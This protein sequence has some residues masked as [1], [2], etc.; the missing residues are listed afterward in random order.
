MLIADAFN[1]GP[2]LLFHGEGLDGSRFVSWCPY[3]IFLFN[4]A[5]D[6]QRARFG[7]QVPRRYVI[8]NKKDRRSTG[9]HWVTAVYEKKSME[10]EATT[11]QSS[12]VAVDAADRESPLI[13]LGPFA[14]IRGGSSAMQAFAGV[15]MC[16][17][18]GINTAPT[19]CFAWCYR[20][21]KNGSFASRLVQGPVPRELKFECALRFKCAL[22]EVCI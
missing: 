8:L 22:P 3:E 12:E 7:H 20:E 6:I 16:C 17:Y 5:H 10:P 13:P 18:G 14:E 21:R 2:S 1:G 9:Y 11:P 4:L 15:C 19:H